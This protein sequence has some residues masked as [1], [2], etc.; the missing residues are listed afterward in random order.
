M[1]QQMGQHAVVFGFPSMDDDS[2][3]VGDD[4]SPTSWTFKVTEAQVSR[5]ADE[6]VTVVDGETVNV[7]KFNGRQTLNLTG[8]PYGATT[9]A[10]ISANVLPKPGQLLRCTGSSGA[11]DDPD[12]IAASTGT[13]WC[14]QTCQ[15][16]VTSNGKV[17]M[18]ITA[19]RW[20][21]ITDYTPLT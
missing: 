10:A 4:G 14:I 13:D 21:G 5:E 2:I 7:T 8:Y 18:T 9:A 16:T 1:A 3:K 12:W 19:M 11:D 17:T 6:E 20:D 15:K